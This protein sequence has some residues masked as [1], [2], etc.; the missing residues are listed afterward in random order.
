MHSYDPRPGDG[1][2]CRACGGDLEWHVMQ[3]Y[4]AIVALRDTLRPAPFLHAR[5]APE[6]I[7]WQIRLFCYRLLPIQLQIGDRWSEKSGEWEIASRPTPTAGGAR[8]NARV[9]RLDR[10][11]W[12]EDRT[13][14]ANERISV[15]RATPL[16]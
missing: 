15:R 5:V 10:S 8:V 9:R 14:V 2:L 11:G 7:G 13:W 12:V 3:S 1:A 6:L 16:S 4:A